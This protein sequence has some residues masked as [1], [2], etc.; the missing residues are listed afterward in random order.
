MKRY[1]YKFIHG[2][3]ERQN[4]M[5]KMVIFDLDGTLLNTLKDLAEAGNYT[6][7][8][9]NYPVHEIDKYRYFIGNGIPKLIERMLP[10]NSDCE[11]KSK[12]LEIF[13]NYYGKHKEDYTEP[14]GGIKE[15]LEVIK[16]KGIKTAVVT[17]K[18]HNFA[19]TIIKKY[20]GNIIDKVYGNR[21]GYPQKPDPYWV[22]KAIEEAS[23][24]KK[25]VLYVGD[26]GVDMEVAVN[27]GVTACGVLW[28][29]R[30]LHE[31][32]EN[33]ADYTCS[34]CS[35]LLNLIINKN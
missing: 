30:D 22:L 4:N 31:L 28:G 25:D 35:E 32:E 29:F 7:K 18:A 17:N 9:M 20:F 12:A 16:S 11:I 13:S 26:S 3:D 6:L 34:D 15:M 27:A 21:E 14:Y 1:L 8:K 23:V 10:E 5:Y 24:E 19:E 2:I 33:G